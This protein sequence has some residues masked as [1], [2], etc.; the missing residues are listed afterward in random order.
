LCQPHGSVILFYLRGLLKLYICCDRSHICSTSFADSLSCVW[1]IWMDSTVPGRRLVRNL[2]VNALA[3]FLSVSFFLLLPL[4]NKSQFAYFVFLFN[5]VF[6]LFGFL[7]VILLL[8]F[9]RTLM[10]N[11]WVTGAIAFSEVHLLSC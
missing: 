6:V 9:C 10:N 5:F 11:T 1:P 7:C 8:F 3:N 2:M 4:S